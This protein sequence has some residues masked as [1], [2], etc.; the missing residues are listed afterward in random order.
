MVNA[1]QHKTHIWLVFID[2]PK[3]HDWCAAT[4][5]TFDWFLLIHKSHNWYAATQNTFDWTTYTDPPP[6]TWLIHC[7]TKS[8]LT[9]LYP[10][11]TPLPCLAITHLAKHIRLDYTL[12]CHYTPCKTH[13]TGLYPCLALHT[14]W[15]ISDW[16]LPLH[17]N[18]GLYRCLALPYT[19]TPPR[20][21][22]TH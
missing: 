6:V 14:L 17:Y 1:L 5:N 3:P 10:R 12:P 18:L 8:H 19:L 7:N 15:N 21:Q 22:W 20:T 2:P 16:I 4:Q 11:I 9:G 13:P